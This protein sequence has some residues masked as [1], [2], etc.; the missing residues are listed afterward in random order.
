MARVHA[1]PLHQIVD[2][3][4]APF[5]DLQET[6][7]VEEEQAAD[8]VERVEVPR[9][10]VDR[11]QILVGEVETGPARVGQGLQTQGLFSSR[12]G[13]MKDAADQPS[14]RP[15]FPPFRIGPMGKAALGEYRPM[16]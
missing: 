6:G 2:R 10:L 13:G 11:G 12:P 9:R 7:A 14:D 5:D 16:P 3:L 8:S 1:K 15:E 4:L